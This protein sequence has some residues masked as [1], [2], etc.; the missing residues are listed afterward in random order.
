MFHVKGK[1]LHQGEREKW[2]KDKT[3]QSDKET[4]ILNCKGIAKIK[5]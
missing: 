1:V 2:I 4:Q 3:E 5:I